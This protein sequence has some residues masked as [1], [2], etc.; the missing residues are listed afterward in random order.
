MIP[1]NWTSQVG[2]RDPG[3]EGRRAT[4]AGGND[5]TGKKTAENA[6]KS[7]SYVHLNA[8]NGY[9]IIITPTTIMI[10]RPDWKMV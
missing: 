4:Q 3:P 7:Y 9:M 10:C 8:T 6:M 1:V 2:R 5:A